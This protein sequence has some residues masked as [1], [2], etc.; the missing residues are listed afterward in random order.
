MK[1]KSLFKNLIVV[2]LFFLTFWFGI[3]PIISGEEFDR[4]LAKLKQPKAKDQY[5]LV[6]CG[7]EPE[8]IA[9]ALSGARMGLKTLLVTEDIDRKSVV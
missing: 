5:S 3:R 7:T 9:A 8:G 1:N 4:R 2:I 6:V